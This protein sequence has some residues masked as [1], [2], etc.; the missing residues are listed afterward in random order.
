M[1][2]AV[3]VVIL[4]GRDL[5]WPEHGNHDD[6]GDDVGDDDGGDAENWIEVG[7]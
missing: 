3:L 2:I 1:Q 4:P 7:K 5:L 6:Q